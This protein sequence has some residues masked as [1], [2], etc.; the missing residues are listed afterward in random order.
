MGTFWIGSWCYWVSGLS[1]ITYTKVV[2]IMRSL[3]G[4]LHGLQYHK[5]TISSQQ[6]E[7]WPCG[8][9][10]RGYQRLKFVRGYSSRIPLLFGHFLF[11]HIHVLN[12]NHI[13][14][15]TIC[16]HL[17]IDKY[18]HLNIYV[19]TISIFFWLELSGES[20]G[21]S[22]M[23]LGGDLSASRRPRVDSRKPRRAY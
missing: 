8:C 3:W 13:Y 18:L 9:A 21:H 11:P 4:K 5:G 17:Q 7:A 12:I 16:M 2:S 10:S 23:K 6:I 1:R 15:Y 20:P 14:I 19:E 22:K